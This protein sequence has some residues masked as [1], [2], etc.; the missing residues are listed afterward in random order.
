MGRRRV[1]PSEGEGSGESDAIDETMNQLASPLG[2][3]RRESHGLFE[4]LK[5]LTDN[6]DAYRMRTGRVETS[7]H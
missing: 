7:V 4:V 5:L 3:V 2:V 1:R 6:H